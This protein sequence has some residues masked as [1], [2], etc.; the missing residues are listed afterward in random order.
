MLRRIS[1]PALVLSLCLCLFAPTTFAQ[2]RSQTPALNRSLS[3]RSYARARQVLLAGLDAL[4][5]LEAMREA[6]DVSVKVRGHSL[7]RNQ[8]L[9]VNPPYDRMTRDEDLYIDVRNRRYIIETRDPLPGGFVFGGRQ[10]IT[11]GQGFFANPRDKTVT[12]LNL[13]NFNNI[14]ILRRLPHLLLLAAYENQPSTLRWLGQEPHDG[15]MHNVVAFASSNGVQWTLFFDAQ[16]NLL[17]KYEQMVSDN[18]AGDAVQETIFPGYRTIGRLKV[19]T[20]RQ[21][22]RAGELIEDVKYEEV[23]FNVRP[24]EST[25]AKPEGYEDLPQ[26]TPPAIKETK[27]ADGVYLFE[28]AVNSLV[29]EFNDYVLV[30]EPPVG[31]RGAKPTIDKAREMFPG[32]PLRYVVVT[33]HHDDH[34]GGVRSYVAEGVTVVTTPANRRY[35]ERMT[36]STFNINP[37]NQTRKPRPITFE[38]IQNKRRIFEDSKQRVEVIDIGPSPHAEEMLVVYLPKEKLVFQGDLVNLTNDGKYAPSTVNEATIHFADAITRLGLDVKRIA[39]VHGPTTT[40]E[41]LR[42]AI[43]KQRR[44]AR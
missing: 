14:G 16:T 25:F 5:G 44:A 29:V 8:S 33:H 12:P 7:A 11:G 30:V 42:E 41:D 3:E 43:E 10:V 22:K 15:R 6:A 32:K 35:F 9:R 37:D 38:F 26:P 18:L 36:T 39:A 23:R 31:G 17:S 20:G 34:S 1:S 24:P 4:G 13:T 19:P 40:L 21:T 28:S 2:R 27:L